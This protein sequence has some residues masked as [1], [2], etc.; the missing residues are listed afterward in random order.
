VCEQACICTRAFA[1][2]LSTR[3]IY[4][5]SADAGPSHFQVSNENKDNIAAKLLQ[6]RFMSDM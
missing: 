6:A 5:G 4:T 3:L 1:G 2:V